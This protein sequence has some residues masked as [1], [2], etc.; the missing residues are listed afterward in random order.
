MAP[1]DL[2]AIYTNVPWRN[3]LLNSLNEL[4]IGAQAEDIR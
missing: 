2:A 1:Y 4:I 3:V